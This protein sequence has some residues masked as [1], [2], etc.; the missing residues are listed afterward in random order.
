M[1]FAFRNLLLIAKKLLSSFEDEITV[2]G[3]SASLSSDVILVQACDWLE[4]RNCDGGSEKVILEGNPGW[5]FIQCEQMAT[6]IKLKLQAWI[7][8]IG[9]CE[10]QLL[11]LKSEIW[12]CCLLTY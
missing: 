9:I 4:C 3:I 5:N 2:E 1:L 10:I 7:E 12:N 8:V 6:S 11:G